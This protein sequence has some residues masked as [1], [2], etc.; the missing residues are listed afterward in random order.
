M[1]AIGW[2]DTHPSLERGL[3]PQP[4]RS[5]TAL[6]PLRGLPRGA[7]VGLARSEPEEQSTAVD[8]Q[9]RPGT[10][11]PPMR[12]A[13]RLARGPQTDLSSSHHNCQ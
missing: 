9:R 8:S 12:R 6:A 4:S 3:L 10:G 2:S 5:L 13:A 1:S 7:V 11:A